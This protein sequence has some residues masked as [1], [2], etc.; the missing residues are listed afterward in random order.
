MRIRF[1][2]SGRPRAFPG[3]ALRTELLYLGRPTNRIALPGTSHEQNC[4]TQDSPRTELLSLGLPTNRIALPG[5]PHEQN[6][7]TW[8]FPRTELLYSVRGESLVEQFCSWGPPG[9]LLWPPIGC[10]GLH[11]HCILQGKL[12][13]GSKTLG[14]HKKT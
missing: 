1:S 4:S 13:L 8:D 14:K 2:G 7:S 6:C 10:P 3:D 12:A 11:F 9:G 5:T